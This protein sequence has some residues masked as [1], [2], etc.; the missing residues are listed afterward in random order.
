MGLGEFTIR[1]S[2]QSAISLITVLLLDFFIFHAVPWS[3]YIILVSGC[4]RCRSH[5]FDVMIAKWA[6]DRPL[7]EQFIKYW[8]NL[9]HLDFG[10]SFVI[11]IG[12]PVATLI[13]KRLLHTI[14]LLSVATIVATLLGIVILKALSNKHNKWQGKLTTGAS[15]IFYSTP[16]YWVGLIILILV[17]SVWM[18]WISPDHFWISPPKD[19]V[20]YIQEYIRVMILPLITLTI[21]TLGAFVSLMHQSLQEV[22]VSNYIV[23]ARAKG[24]KENVILFKHAMKNTLSPLVRS[25]PLSFAFVISGTIFIEAVFGWN[26][27]GRLLF[28][29]IQFNDFPVLE[30]S[31]LTIMTTAIIANL[32]VN[33]LYA[34]LIHE[35]GMAKCKIKTLYH[36]FFFCFH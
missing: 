36:F 29:A 23:A 22:F 13:A 35:Y 7:W 12:T 4:Y 32:I 8:R 19:Q 3:P 26:S 33:I 2:T 24:L 11:S 17:F 18:H 25:W 10:L 14:I 31:F 1:K 6:F 34:Y 9:L 16:P 28:T 27:V 20:Q 15:M 21:L 5:I 30:F